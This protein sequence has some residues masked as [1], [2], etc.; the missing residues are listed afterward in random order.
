MTGIEKALI[1]AAEVIGYARDFVDGY[2]DVVDGDYGVPRPNTAMQLAQRF[3]EA[4]RLIDD[5]LNDPALSLP[6]R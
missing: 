2:I 5:A 3:D 6:Y 1:E 4:M